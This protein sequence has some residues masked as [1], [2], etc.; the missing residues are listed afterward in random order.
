MSPA[1]LLLLPLLVASPPA[2]DP[3]SELADIYKAVHQAYL[4][5]GHAIPGRE[6]AGAYLLREWAGLGVSAPEESLLVAGFPG[7]PF[8]RVHLRPYRDRGGTIDSLLAAFLRSGTVPVDSGAF[9]EAWQG[10]GASIRRGDLPFAPAAYDS[11]EALLSSLGYPAIHHSAAY[12]AAHRPAYRV[13][14]RREAERLLRSLPPLARPE[15]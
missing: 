10:V 14:A 8:V 4:G 1:I 9:R 5:P 2:V 13:V 15:D 3:G 7:A 12:A 6:A 11:L